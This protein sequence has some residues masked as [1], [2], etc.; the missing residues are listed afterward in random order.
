MGPQGPKRAQRGK[1]CPAFS[2]Y[3]GLLDAILD[4]YAAAGTSHAHNYVSYCRNFGFPGQFSCDFASILGSFAPLGPF[5]PF[6]GL[7]GPF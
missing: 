4:Q 6:W 3:L 1:I 2:G 5:G 7:S